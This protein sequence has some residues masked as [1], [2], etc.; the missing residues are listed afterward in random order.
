MMD[1]LRILR[2]SDALAGIAI[3]AFLACMIFLTGALP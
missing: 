3:T 2:I 1:M